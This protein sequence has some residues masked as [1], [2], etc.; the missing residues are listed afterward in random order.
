VISHADR[1][2]S[3]NAYLHTL[4][5]GANIS[6]TNLALHIVGNSAL[7]DIN[8]SENNNSLCSID[9]VVYDIAKTTM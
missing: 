6:P 5:L 9:G 1:S 4:N 2:I 8:V 7:L 3:D